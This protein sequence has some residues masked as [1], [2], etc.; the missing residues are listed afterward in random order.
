VGR[1]PGQA[2]IIIHSKEGTAQG[3]G[4]AIQ[5]YGIALLPLCMRMN[6]ELPGVLKP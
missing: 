6:E 3:Y 1:A 5:A 2:P 4:M